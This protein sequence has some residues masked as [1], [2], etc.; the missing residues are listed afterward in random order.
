MKT[1]KILNVLLSV[2]IALPMALSA[3]T[4]VNR[5][6]YPDYS[7]IYNPDR[8][9]LESSTAQ[10]A[11]QRAATERPEYVNNAEEIFF[12][13]VFNQDGGSCG[14]ASR[15]CYMFTYE[16]NAYRNLYGK[17]S[18]NYY[19]S[20]FVW[21]LRMEDRPT[22]RHSDT[23]I[24]PTMILAGCRDMTNGSKQCITVCSTP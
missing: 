13:P 16:L 21:L 11:A 17:F 4:D 14:S 15:I 24:A 9:L 19:P 1:V 6:K 23:K 3:Q 10:R 7:D 12:P 5:E 22:L 8:S 20:H 18:K 2:A